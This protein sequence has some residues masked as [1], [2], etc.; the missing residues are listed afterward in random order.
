MLVENSVAPICEAPRITFQKNLVLYLV[1]AMEGKISKAPEGVQKTLYG[2]ELCG[3]PD[4]QGIHQNSVGKIKNAVF[5]IPIKNMDEHFLAKNISEEEK[6]RQFKILAGI[7]E[8]VVV[9]RK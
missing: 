4:Y 2:K 9:A 3:T 1:T 8:T 5:F 6:S 7:V